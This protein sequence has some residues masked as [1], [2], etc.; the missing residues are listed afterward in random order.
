MASEGHVQE[1]LVSRAKDIAGHGCVQVPLLSSGGSAMN[2][3]QCQIMMISVMEGL[4][5]N[6]PQVNS[7]GPVVALAHGS[8]ASHRRAELVPVSHSLFS[9]AT[10][11]THPSPSSACQVAQPA[12]AYLFLW[13]P[14]NVATLH[15]HQVLKFSE[16]LI[17]TVFV[18]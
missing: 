17:A 13:G 1:D 2:G 18:L 14:T 7:S 5:L 11:L 4:Y 8:V 9:P 3:W 10:T 6:K 16:Y 15:P 12:G